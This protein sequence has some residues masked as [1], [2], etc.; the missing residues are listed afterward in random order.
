MNPFEQIKKEWKSQ[1]EEPDIDLESI[2]SKTKMELFSQQRKLI[3]TNLFVSIS[4][5]AVFIVLGWVWNSFPD[6]SPYFYV[7]LVSM[8]LLL[9]F[10]LAGF[11]AGVQY[12]NEE[13]YKATGEY[14]KARIKKLS[15]RKFMIEKFLPVYLVLLLSFFYMYY[16]DILAGDSLSYTLSVYA[17]TTLFFIFVYL[18]SRKKQR[19]KVKE[20]DELMHKL[21]KWADEFQ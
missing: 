11:W 3:F 15:I 16:A 2:R 18:I 1:Q 17:G 14:L 10:T 5:A 12:K 8:G 7:S 20:I 21:R 13:S 4:F 9:L 6:R 19:R